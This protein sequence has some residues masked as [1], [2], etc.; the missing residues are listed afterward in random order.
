MTE[1]AANGGPEPPR[2]RSRPRHAPEMQAGIFRVPGHSVRP[3]HDSYVGRPL[4]P[5]LDEWN[6]LA[7]ED[8]E[9]MYQ[10]R[11]QTEERLWTEGLGVLRPGEV[12]VLTFIMGRTFRYRKYVERI[13]ER[14]FV[15][16]IVSQRTGEVVAAGL[17]MDRGTLRRHLASLVEQEWVQ[18]W[19]VERGSRVLPCYMPLS[20]ARLLEALVKAGGCVASEL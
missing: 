7:R 20:E 5:D 4:S 14:T 19:D 10:V 16:G 12:A 18:R 13:P 3:P 17:R 6:R 15:E 8:T 9:M 2:R 1:S 11:R